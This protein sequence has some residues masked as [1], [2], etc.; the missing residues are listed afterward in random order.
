[1]RHRWIVTAALC[2][3]CAAGLAAADFWQTKPYTGWSEKEVEQMLSDS[4]WAR[5]LSVVIQMPPRESGDSGDRGGRG[6]GMPAP[7]LKMTLTWRSAPPVRQAL[8]RSDKSGATVID[9][10]PFLERPPDYLLALSNV[11]GYLRGS[12]PAAA[13]TS[14]LRRGQKAAIPLR[15]GAIQQGR[16]GT[17]TLVFAF[18]RTDPITLDDKEVEFI[19]TLGTLEIKQKFKLKDLVVNGELEL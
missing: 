3:L 17:L 13:K 6:F 11:P 9:G 12:L 1:M 16:G 14:F 5:K 2:A 15:Q 18:P 8:A 19:T 10:Q 4:P 7:Q